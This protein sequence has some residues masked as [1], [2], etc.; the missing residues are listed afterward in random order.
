MD[1]L[2]VSSFVSGVI[3]SIMIVFL[4]L[5]LLKTTIVNEYTKIA[6]VELLLAVSL[7]VVFCFLLGTGGVL[8]WYGTISNC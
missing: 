8:G 4:A 1:W 3:F 5:V 2:I 7:R 6:Y